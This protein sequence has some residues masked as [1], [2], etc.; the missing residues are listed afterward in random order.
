MVLLET[1]RGS[2]RGACCGSHAGAS[3]GADSCGRESG[4]CV[5]GES[6]G[7]RGVWRR[8]GVES[9]S[10]GGGKGGPM[11]SGGSTSKWTCFL[12]WVW[13]CSVGMRWMGGGLGEA[14]S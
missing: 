5:Y 13:S 14:A 9:A 3:R 8:G 7:R 11:M 6:G 2:A 10:V 12:C 4:G 1:G